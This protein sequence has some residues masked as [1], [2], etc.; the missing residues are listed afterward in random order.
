MSDFSSLLYSNRLAYH[1]VMRVLYGR[2]FDAR[3]EAVAAEIPPGASV[4]DVC[5]GDGYLYLKCLRQ[6]SV[7][8]LALDISPSLV[9]WANRH[10]IPAQQFNVWQDTPPPGDIVVMQAS[11][12]QFLP[13]ADAIVR[14]LLAAARQKVII[15]EPIRNLSASSHPLLSLVSRRLTAPDSSGEHYT[16][17]RFDRQSLGALFRAFDAFERE[18]IAPGGREMIGIFRGQREG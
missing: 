10:G 14:N 15:A 3:Y 13:H 9:A 11:L 18:F 17:Q 7:R 6:K 4:V 12:Y 5:A 2:H 8:Y 16:G 1:L